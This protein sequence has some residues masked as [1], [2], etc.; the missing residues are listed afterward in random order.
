MKIYAYILL[1]RKWGM[2]VDLMNSAGGLC[3]V[4]MVLKSDFA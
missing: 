3:A 1:L 2:I 4:L